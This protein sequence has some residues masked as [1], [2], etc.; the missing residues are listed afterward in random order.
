MR[1]REVH[2]T[3]D[4]K[5]AQMVEKRL[6]EV[7]K[8]FEE[9]SLVFK[10][11][12]SS[13]EWQDAQLREMA[14]GQELL[15]QETDVFKKR[16][17]VL[18]GD[19]DLLR[20]R[21]IDGGMSANRFDGLQDEMV[22]A[23]AESKELRSLDEVVQMLAARLEEETDRRSSG[24]HELAQE[25]AMIRQLITGLYAQLNNLGQI[26]PAPQMQ[27]APAL[28]QAPKERG[29]ELQPHEKS[30]PQE[31]SPSFWQSLWSSSNDADLWKIE[32]NHK[33]G[34]PSAVPLSPLMRHQEAGS[35]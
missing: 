34:E 31:K 15:R 5:V 16:L 1:V 32:L 33:D 17:D 6:N 18:A 13:M 4:V 9:W 12:Q 21:D 11:F 29:I 27:E 25:F 35:P 20:S 3:I 28:R 22:R 26:Q 10:G 14:R 19:V 7:F 24:D 8:R 2:D 23:L 30:Q